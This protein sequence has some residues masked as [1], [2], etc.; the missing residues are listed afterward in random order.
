MC[1][2]QQPSV[3]L[4][5]ETPALSVPYLRDRR[6]L[7]GHGDDYVCPTPLTVRERVSVH[8]M[9]RAGT[10]TE[11]QTSAGNRY[12]AA[13]APRHESGTYTRIHLDI[14]SPLYLHLVLVAPQHFVHPFPS[15]HLPS[16]GFLQTP[17]VCVDLPRTL[18][19][20]YVGTCRFVC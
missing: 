6:T 14:L 12:T 11:G 5:D 18:H 8:T 20:S 4:G 9:T 3:E 19:V 16:E 10:P 15:I 1:E 17:P 7:L 13:K 2:E